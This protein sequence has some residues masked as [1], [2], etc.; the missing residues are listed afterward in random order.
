MSEIKKIALYIHIP[1]CESKCYY[2]DFNSFSGKHELIETYTNALIKEVNHYREKLS[3]YEISTIFFGGGTPSILASN[4]ISLIMESILSNFNISKN[5]EISIEANP[6]TLNKLKLQSYR[7]SG[8]NRLS[9][10]LQSCNAAYLKGLG[11][12]HTFEE[13]VSNLEDARKV[14]FTNINVDLMFALPNMKIKEWE[15][16]LIQINNLEIPHISAYSLIWEE[17]TKFQQLKQGG[18]IKLID[19][20]E[21]LEMYHLTIEYLN[22]KGYSHYEISNYA[23][24]GYE[25]KHNITYWKNQN[26]LGLGAGAHSYFENRRF[27]NANRIEDYID[28]ISKE[29]STAEN[30]LRISRSDEISETMFL[31]LR[32]T[33]GIVV[34]EFVKR[35]NE[36]PFTIYRN[37]LDKLREQKLIFFDDN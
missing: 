32:M 36:S 4:Q 13:F 8:I 5:A 21:E 30:I 12:I 37:E 16:C 17:G 7:D 24:K 33:E 2:C 14:G 26:Y 3:Q 31:G 19:E 15:N 34:E 10:G 18:Y 29:H 27:N 22:S 20:D 25:C 9:M 35:F 23:K 11:R 28:L 6:G 1:F